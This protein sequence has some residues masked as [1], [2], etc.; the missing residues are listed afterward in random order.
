MLKTAH[1]VAR[2][3]STFVSARLSPTRDFT[4]TSTHAEAV[5]A[6]S[7]APQLTSAVPARARQVRAS[8]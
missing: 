5:P 1:T 7:A 2:K 8:A 6:V 3:R 4:D